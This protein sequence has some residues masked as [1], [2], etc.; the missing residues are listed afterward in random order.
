MKTVT[1]AQ[2][3]R[4]LV[5]QQKFDNE[6]CV[7]K[8]TPNKISKKKTKSTEQKNWLPKLSGETIVKK[9]IKARSFNSQG[10][11]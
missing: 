2:G 3:R 9:K 6:K 7:Y 1:L 5:L 11:I 8:N 4:L 10:P